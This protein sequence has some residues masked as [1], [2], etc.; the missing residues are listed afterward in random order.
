MIEV[1]IFKIHS[2]KG[3]MPSDFGNS[4]KTYTNGGN[5]VSR[6]ALRGKPHKDYDNSYWGNNLY[7]E[8]FYD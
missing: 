5:F 7:C 8:E 1:I 6:G 3:N 4:K 2:L